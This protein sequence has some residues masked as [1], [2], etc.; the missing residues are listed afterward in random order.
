[1][2]LK[3]YGHYFEIR[4][5]VKLKYL[6]V[7]AGSSPTIR[8]IVG[9]SLVFLCF[10][11]RVVTH[12][13]VHSKSLFRKLK[14]KKMFR[15]QK[16]I[17]RCKILL[18]CWIYWFYLQSSKTK[19]YRFCVHS[20]ITMGKNNTGWLEEIATGNNSTLYLGHLIHFHYYFYVLIYIVQL[21]T[22]R[23]VNLFIFYFFIY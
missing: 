12:S 10:F 3:K 9:I 5:E 8:S 22:F 23:S 17:F 13:G 1:M 4:V 16:L 19:R 7:Q 15:I 18:K 20:L 11:Y 14:K 21:L 6:L 2:I